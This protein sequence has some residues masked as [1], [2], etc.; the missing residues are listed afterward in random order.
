M[1]EVGSVVGIMLKTF[2]SNSHSRT[3]VFP[4]EFLIGAG[5]SSELARGRGCWRG[6]LSFAQLLPRYKILHHVEIQEIEGPWVSL[7]PGFDSYALVD[8]RPRPQRWERRPPAQATLGGSVN[9]LPVPGDRDRQ[10]PG[11]QGLNCQLCCGICAPVSLAAA[12]RIEWWHSCRTALGW[13]SSS[14][15]LYTNYPLVSF[16]LKHLVSSI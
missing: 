14:Q 6:Q 3:H 2:Y 4:C 9:F 8:A 7:W 10:Q 16:P 15:P 11:P 13:R 12:A 1:I 5:F